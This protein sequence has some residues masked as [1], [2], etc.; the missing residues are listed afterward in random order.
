MPANL[1]EVQMRYL[2]G[3]E[4]SYHHLTRIADAMLAGGRV[5]A[6][7]SE[8]HR[9]SISLAAV[10]DQVDALTEPQRREKRLRYDCSGADVRVRLRCDREKVVQILLNMISNSI[11]F[12]PSGG[13]I[14]VGT[15]RPAADRVAIVVA[16]SGVGMS[17]R[18]L[19]TVFEPF[20]QFENSER[21]GGSGMGLGMAISRQYARSMGGDITVASEP[22]GGTIFA[23]WLPTA[24]QDPR[25]SRTTPS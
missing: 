6:G 9:G 20:T 11:K 7:K 3:I 23:L 13:L 8:D 14:T 22:G 17:G 25:A 16:D 10:L 19:E 21:T 15:E 24:A 12:T 18:E 5:D 2:R 1:D 4:R